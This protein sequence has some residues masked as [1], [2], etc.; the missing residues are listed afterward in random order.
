MKIGI[1]TFHCAYNYGAVIQCYCLQEFLTLLGHDVY[2][3]DYRPDYL[4]TPYRVFSL[5]NW[6]SL[7]FSKTVHKMITEPSLL[8]YRIKRKN[9]FE[10]FIS[11]TLN[12][13]SVKECKKISL[14]AILYGSDQIW[15]SKINHGFFDD[16][17]FGIGLEGKK[18]AY[19]ASSKSVELSNKEKV[20]YES[21]LKKF[22]SISVRE[23][24]LAN[25]IRPLTN[26]EVS[27][28]LD[29]SLLVPPTILNNISSHLKYDGYILTYDIIPN[30]KTKVLGERLSKLYNC[31]MI[32]LSSSI[33]YESKE[34]GYMLGISPYDFLGY[35]QK[36]RFV[37]TTSFHG[38]ALSIKLNKD[39]YAIKQNNNSDLRLETLLNI[40]DL[41]SRFVDDNTDLEITSIAYKKVDIKLEDAI[42]ASKKFIKKALNENISLDTYK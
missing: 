8:R 5:Q 33:T 3:I 38:V 26:K 15:N 20:Y 29:P 7:S 18:I 11:N 17:Y 40:L 6:F 13:L 36:A 41:E 1:L 32:E 12:L 27:V 14:D 37:V 9:T 22:H 28:V 2:V 16:F 23:L 34:T 4:V 10:N 39:F 31:R 42:N 30:K 35:I 25:L 24:S 21:N 19:A